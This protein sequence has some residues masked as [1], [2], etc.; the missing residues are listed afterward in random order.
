M[1][2]QSTGTMSYT[3]AAIK[4][5]REHGNRK[6]MHYKDIVNTAIREGWL[7]PQGLTPAT[8]LT[9]SIGQ[10]NR[11]R[12]A[13]EEIPR[14]FLE[15]GG[16]YGLTEWR[17]SSPEIK[18]SEQQSQ[19]LQEQLITR[20]HQ[21][22]PYQFEAFIA[23]LLTEMGFVKV[24]LK[25]G[26]GDK[27]IDIEAE[28]K[29]QEFGTVSTIVQVKRYTPSTKIGPDIVRNLI[30]AF[31]KGSNAT[32][33]LLITTAR[34]GYKA[35]QTALDAREEIWLVDG[36][37]LARL[38]I[39][40]NIGVKERSIKELDEQFFALPSAKELSTEEQGA[41]LTGEVVTETTHKA[42]IGKIKKSK[43]QI[44]K[45]WKLS[46]KVRDKT[47]EAIV[48][49][50]GTIFY[51]G[52]SYGSPSGAAKAATNTSRDGWEFWHYQDSDSGE[53][54]PLDELRHK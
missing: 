46:G 29:I 22:P 10:E 34:F 14:F 39:Q 51:N 53:W 2:N 17:Q 35:K 41:A 4:V 21:M 30:G 15:G 27:G 33:G 23:T 9:A 5:L 40:Y 52:Y 1:R 3:E 20:L 6:P 12:E 8:T 24:Q 32:Y 42:N 16:L 44:P 11:R 45:G 54:V 31:T 36:A 48:G 43:V 47:F 38:M 28:L 49:E 13:R 7:A 18:D 37:E 26:S 19:Q 50:G 25:G